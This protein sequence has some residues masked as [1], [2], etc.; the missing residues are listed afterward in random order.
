MNRKDED[1]YIILTNTQKQLLTRVRKTSFKP[2]LF[3]TL[4]FRVDPFDGKMN[5]FNKGLMEKQ[6]SWLDKHLSKFMCR[7]NQFYY[8]RRWHKKMKN[9]KQVAVQIMLSIEISNGQYH[10]HF[11]A[12]TPD[13]KY[14][15]QHLFK[16][17]LKEC[18]YGL[19]YCKGSQVKIKPVWWADGAIAYISKDF[20]KDRGLGFVKHSNYS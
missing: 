16:G 8:G 6:F 20:N 3:G 10:C 7:L 14:C 15:G 5:T 1:G 12:Q 13:I 18:W 2:D 11:V 9:D 4:T 17:I 19:P